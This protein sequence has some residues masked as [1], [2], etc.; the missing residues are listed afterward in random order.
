MACTNPAVVNS[1]AVSTRASPAARAALAVTGPMQANSGSPG[2][3]SGFSPL[4]CARASKFSTLEG[5]VQV[6]TSTPA[7]SA[8][9]PAGSNTPVLGKTIG[10]A[11]QAVTISSGTA[12]VWANIEK[13]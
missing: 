9:R 4:R 8:A 2:R 5:L 11:L 1:S 12:L 6:I 7:L 3:A 13:Y 10:V